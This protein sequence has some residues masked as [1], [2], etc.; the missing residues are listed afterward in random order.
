MGIELGNIQRAIRP[1]L[2]AVFDVTDR[3]FA[4]GARGDG[5]RDD[6]A[7]IR[8]AVSAAAAAGGGS[9][10]FPAGDF[11][12]SPITVSDPHVRLLGVGYGSRLL[13]AEA[14]TA[15][16]LTFTAAATR[17][18]VEGM[19]V[20]GADAGTSTAAGS[21]IVLTGTER[22]YVRRCWVDGGKVSGILLQSGASYCDIEGTEHSG[23]NASGVQTDA[24]DIR[25]YK[26]AHIG[27]RI[28]GCRCYSANKTTGIGLM[29][30][31]DAAAITRCVVRDNHVVGSLA[32]F[33]AHGIYIY[34]AT[35]GGGFEDIDI[36]DNA[37]EDVHGMGIY[38]QC[39]QATT[40]ATNCRIERNR[41]RNYVQ[42]GY[43]GTLMDAAIGAV[44]MIGGSIRN[45]ELSGG[46][47][48]TDT[49][50]HGIHVKDSIRVQ[51][52]GNALDET[53]DLWR[54][55]RL[56][57]DTE[58]CLVAHNSVDGGG[59][60]TNVGILIEGS[61]HRV[62]GNYARNCNTNL[63]LEN[64]TNATVEGNETADGVVYGLWIRSTSTDNRVLSHE[65]TGSATG[66]KD[67]GTGNATPLGN[68]SGSSVKQ[69]RVYSANLTPTVSVPAASTA[70]EVFTFTGL[71]TADRV[72]VNNRTAMTAGTGIVGARVSA[73]DSLA[74]RFCN[75]TAGALTP[76]AGT[77]AVIAI[78]V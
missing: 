66:L 78:R 39:T 17:S 60:T 11:L 70:E 13:S 65:D 53:A 22:G 25:V 67:D 62:R 55:I 19:R 31:D 8:A 2:G 64:C 12:S 1:P 20:S 14:T 23:L 51:I 30:D 49:A 10:Y 36:R 42:T 6:T 43:S 76:A 50:D 34:V 37:I 28:V 77:F 54:G 59:S 41:V 9:V 32:A 21:V 72:L 48:T 61:H 44:G 52:T 33:N 27:H 68:A 46:N 3:Q 29:T 35:G 73:A 71:T 18:G 74:V 38:V 7:A 4:G 63:M 15:T 69:F 58:R 56:E 57:S 40:P 45:N 24:V 47:L 5:A 16:T 75:T 26:G